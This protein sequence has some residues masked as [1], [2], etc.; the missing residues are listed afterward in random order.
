VKSFNCLEKQKL[1]VQACGIK[2][3]QALS[4]RSG[5][6]ESSELDQEGVGKYEDERAYSS[7]VKSSQPGF[8][9]PD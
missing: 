9:T 5:S 6:S 3:I 4:P 1:H 7:S 8:I 2:S